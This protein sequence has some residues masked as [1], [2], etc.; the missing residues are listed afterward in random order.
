MKNQRWKGDDQTIRQQFRSSR[1]EEQM[2]MNAVNRSYGNDYL[3]STEPSLDRYEVE[4]LEP[5]WTT[6]LDTVGMQPHSREF[7]ER[8][9]NCLRS[10]KKY[11]MIS[12]GHVD[13]SDGIQ[14]RGT[15]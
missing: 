13:Y 8:E 2:G 4:E 11:E 14:F 1:E 3:A 12:G 15:P 5:S 6:Q 9:V 7:L 10:W